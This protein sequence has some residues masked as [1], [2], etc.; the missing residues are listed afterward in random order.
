MPP[1]FSTFKGARNFFASFFEIIIN[2]FG[3]LWSLA[4]FATN[5]FGPIPIE[6]V[7]LSLPKSYCQLRV[8]DGQHRLLGFAKVNDRIKRSTYLPVIA[9]QRAIIDLVNY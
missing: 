8:I 1:N 3:F 6:Q 9:F 5:L 7:R 4:I 2:P